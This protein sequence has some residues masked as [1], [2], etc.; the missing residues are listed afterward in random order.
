MN[1]FLKTFFRITSPMWVVFLL[2]E[3]LFRFFKDFFTYNFSFADWPMHIVGGLVAAWTGYL[4]LKFIKA[5]FKPTWLQYLLLIGFACFAAVIWEVYEFYHDLFFQGWRYQ[6][7]ALDTM[8]DL[9]NGL[10]GAVLFCVGLWLFPPLY[11]GK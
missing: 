5:E 1:K 6:A 3:F 8:A 11:K 4:F 9:A 2:N 7:G 10:T